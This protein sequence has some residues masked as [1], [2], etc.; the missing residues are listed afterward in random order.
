MKT[1]E[2]SFASRLRLTTQSSRA[3]LP[4]LW[5]L[6]A[7]AATA[8]AAHPTKPTEVCLN[9]QGH[10]A[11]VRALAFSRDSQLLCT[12][13]LDK[14]VHVWRL[15]ASRPKPGGTMKAVTGEPWGKVRTLHWEISRG[16]R[17]AIYAMSL[18]P[19]TGELAIGGYGCRSATGDIAWLNPRLGG[20]LRARYSHRESI[21]GLCHSA[22]GECLA[23]MDIQ[24]QAFLWPAGGGEPLP[25]APPDRVRG[26][27]RPIILVGEST[28]VLP[29]CHRQADGRPVWRLQKVAV[30]DVRRLGSRAPRQELEADH[31]GDVTALAASID[32][33]Y[34]ASTDDRGSVFV[35]QLDS[36]T[37]WK[38]LQ[39]AG[40]V[41][42]LAL[43]PDGRVLVAGTRTTPHAPNTALSIY[44]V[45]TE[46]V[47]RQRRLDANVDACAI[48]PDGQRVAYAGGETH[49]VHVEWLTPPSDRITIPGGNRLAKVAFVREGS[50]Y[51]VAF[52][53]FPYQGP[54][55]S[56]R[57]LSLSRLTVENKSTPDI[58]SS[59][60]LGNWSYVAEPETNRLWLYFDRQPQ[61]HVQL[62]P[63]RHG[64]LQ[65]QCWV[66]GPEGQPIGVAVGTELQNG[67][68]VFGLPHQGQCPMLRYCRGHYGRVTTLG[69]SRDGK[70]LVSGATD[71]TIRFWSLAH[72][73]DDPANEA[74]IF[75]RWGGRL[76]PTPDG[77][78]LQVSDLDDLGPFYQKGV[79][80]GD[81]VQKIMWGTEQ[82]PQVA[83]ASGEMLRQLADLPW[84]LQVYF[85][86]QRQGAERPV[87]ALRGGWHHIVAVYASDSEWIA[88]TPAGYYACSP[89]GER[90][91]GWVENEDKA[92]EAPTF[93]T[94]EQLNR[95][96]Y[97]P[98]VIG[99]ILEAGSLR[100]A[101]EAS[102][103]GAQQVDSPA[104]VGRPTVRIITPK[105]RVVVQDRPQLTVT[106]EASAPDGQ[107]VT[108]MRLHLDGVPLE[109]WAS[110]NVS[111]VL[112]EETRSWVVELPP[113]RHVIQV[114]AVSGAAEGYSEEISATYEPPGPAVPARP[115]LYVFAAG[116]SPYPRQPLKF[117]D[118]DAESI[119]SILQA[120]T[121]PLF[122]KRVVKT[123]LNE[124]A[125]KRRI[126]EGLQWL[127]DKPESVTDVGVFFFSG[128]GARDE[129]GGF[130]LVPYDGKFDDLPNT[131]VPDTL[132][133]Q[134]CEV[135]KGKLVMMLDACHSGAIDL[136]TSRTA[137]LDKLALEFSRAEYSV[138]LMASSTGNEVS[139]E[140]DDWQAGAFAKAVSEGL[141]GQANSRAPFADNLILTNELEL[142]VYN[143]V[144]YQL[145]KQKQT[146]VS[147][148]PL[149]TP[150]ALT[151]IESDGF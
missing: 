31:Y 47:I 106:A 145:T 9:T 135:R 63:L 53:S 33:R 107:A 52:R 48:S 86:T 5:L 15:P 34:F 6:L 75:N 64:R 97:R 66:R 72:C 139:W 4:V 123:C 121:A 144:F 113:G 20:F 50:P 111:L 26:K 14:V 136:S 56:T 45:S 79:R 124:Q 81:R 49:E 114:V 32:G 40:P 126:V 51:D 18:N 93:Y 89:G 95:A 35:W 22:N 2:S 55:A 117:A 84:D 61:G 110:K 147:S 100:R 19:R 39:P 70:Y 11:P 71:G 10:T 13:G 1:A 24:G 99:K 131:C 92:G 151:A 36:R 82:S 90:M 127:H 46:R 88:W 129:S 103:S 69:T 27:H 57:T 21:S 143:R 146:P 83:E 76:T 3:F 12:A 87:F 85:F 108:A 122:E 142:Y 148:K 120:R 116:I 140:H 138:I 94:A 44:D 91:I 112:P 77:R 149:I 98:A 104:E 38:R 78:G 101:F 115:S 60:T 141:L 16:L 62:D 65:S 74:R 8:P 128:H 42:S 125:S 37:P 58:T 43:S 7:L 150:F 134:L 29:A 73:S 109:K 59:D 96:L 25:L 132:L 102:E 68:F 28:V 118:K 41:V 67:V 130:H 137:S 17:G 54:T 119:A 80:A 23:S 30:S 133:K 105:D